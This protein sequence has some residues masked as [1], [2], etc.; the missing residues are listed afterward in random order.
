MITPDGYQVEHPVQW[1]FSKQFKKLDQV[2]ELPVE[3][4]TFK[5]GA[6]LYNVVGKT[7]FEIPVLLLDTEI[8]GNEEWQQSFT[9][10]LYDATPF[11]RVVQ[12]LILGLAG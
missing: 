2:I 5:V 4:K 8:E 1:K 11:Q 3:D 6:W 10:I 12:E 7:G 9:H